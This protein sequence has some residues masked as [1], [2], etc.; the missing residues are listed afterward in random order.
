MP[1]QSEIVLNANRA[2]ISYRDPSA[3]GKLSYNRNSLV[4]NRVKRGSPCN[5]A[6]TARR[7]LPPRP[8]FAPRQRDMRIE[9]PS[10]RHKSA[11]LRRRS[12]L[13]LQSINSC[14][15]RTPAKNTPARSKNPS[16]SSAIATGRRPHRAQP[17]HDTRVLLLARFAEKLQRN[18]PCFSRRPAQP[19]VA[20]FEPR[21]DRRQAPPPPQPP[22]ESQQTNAYAASLVPGPRASPLSGSRGPPALQFSASCIHCI[23]ERRTPTARKIAIAARRL[24]DRKARTP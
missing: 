17:L 1:C 10:L 24:L 13:L 14:V 21:P 7:P 11:K 9:R 12:H 2:R 22:A 5:F 3:P 23:H 16:P 6:R 18:M 8:A 4:T 15:K 20:R 19:V